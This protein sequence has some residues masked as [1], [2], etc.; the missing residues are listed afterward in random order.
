VFR[1]FRLGFDYTFSKPILKGILICYA[2]SFLLFTPAAVLTPLMVDRSFA[3]GVWGLTANELLWTFGS[4]LGGI[5][6]SLK[7][8]FKDKIRT[9]AIC[10]FAF[11]ITFSLLGLAGNMILYLAFMGIADLHAIIITAETVLIQK[12]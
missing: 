11:G 2:F 12:L 8:E 1:E 10:I 6:V 3:G 7:G 9:I 5:F 4:L